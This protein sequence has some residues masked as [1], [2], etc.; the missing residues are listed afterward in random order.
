M[1]SVFLCTPQNAQQLPLRSAEFRRRVSLDTP[2]SSGIYV[3]MHIPE[4]PAAASRTEFK[5]IVSLDIQVSSGSV[6]VLPDTPPWQSA[7]G[8]PTQT[9]TV[10]CELAWRR[11]LANSPFAYADD[12]AHR[13]S[14]LPRLSPR[15]L[16]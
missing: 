9:N 15:K 3:P 5:R 4:C 11:L 10:S 1:V 12:M 2:V 7:E 16:W 8:L 6:Y 14:P 13:F